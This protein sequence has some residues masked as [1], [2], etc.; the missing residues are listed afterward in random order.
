MADSWELPERFWLPPGTGVSVLCSVSY[1]SFSSAMSFKEQTLQ[2][3]T[4][5][6]CPSFRSWSAL[7]APRL[8]I[9]GRFVVPRAAADVCLR[10]DG[11]SFCAESAVHIASAL[12]TQRKGGR[13]SASP[14]L[15]RGRADPALPPG[16]GSAASAL[17]T[18]A[19][20]RWPLRS[21]LLPGSAPQRQRR[22]PAHG[23][24]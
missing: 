11:V 21:A 9:T 22:T 10:D 15:T 5:P 12:C 16:A 4:S 3:W 7:S 17:T 6:A 24:F 20:L 23:S 19:H 8:A 13:G 14:M 18:R 2:T 1:L